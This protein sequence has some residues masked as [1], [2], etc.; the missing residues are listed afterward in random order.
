MSHQRGGGARLSL[1]LW[2]ELATAIPAKYR[3]S[4]QQL[5][6]ALWEVRDWLWPNGWKRSRMMPRLRHAMA[7]VDRMRFTTA[8]PGGG[9][10]S[11]RAVGFT[12]I[13]PPNARLDDRAIAHIELPPGSGHG[14]LIHRPSLRALGLHSAPQYR[15]ALGMAYHWWD[16]AINGKY[17]LPQRRRLARSPTG[18]PVTI[19]GEIITDRQGSP[20]NNKIMI[21]AGKK[22]KPH[23]DLVWLDQNG[24]RTTFEH[25]ALEPNPTAS[26]RY[27][28][29]EGAD[30]IRLFHP[31]VATGA[32]RR[33]QIKRARR[34]LEKMAAAGLCVIED[35]DGGYRI[36]PPQWWGPK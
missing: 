4:T 16:R 17:I 15:A 29:F 28:I 25:A 33:Q 5:Q 27:P 26:A 22:R 8:L 36:M 14:P 13:F 30:L 10:T 11:W 12:G 9:R 21:I 24:E 3:D 19:T 32:N 18:L 23:P 20:I 6:F 7:E 2:V 35:I 31:D 1:R 34:E